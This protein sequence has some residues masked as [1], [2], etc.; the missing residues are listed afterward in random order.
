MCRPE[1]LLALLRCYTVFRTGEGGKTEKVV[2]RY[3]QFRAVEKALLRLRNGLNPRERSGIIWHTQGAG[4]SLTMLFLVRRMRFLDE[5]APWKIIF[6]TD[7]TDLENQLAGTASG[8]GQSVK[9]AEDIAKL[10]EYVQNPA[11][12]L[13]MGMIH[14]FQERD[15]STIFPVLNNSP[16]ILT[17]TDE[18]H[19]TQYGLLG[20]NFDRAV[21][22]AARIA[23]TGTPIAKTEE[24]FG[25]YIDKYTMRESI[26]DGTT[27]EIVYEGRTH[28]AEVPDK[29]GMDAAFED[30]F[31]EYNLAERLQILGYGSRDAYLEADPTIAA[32][33]KD[34]I[35]HYV[36]GIFTR[37]FKGQV[38]A[39]SQEA[40][41]RYKEHLEAALQD[42]IARLE[43]NNPNNVNL[44]QLKG[45]EVAVIISGIDRNDR[46]HL[47][48]FG[49]K[50]DHETA[51]KRFKLAFGEVSGDGAGQVNGQVGLLVVHNMLIT[52]F[53]APIEQVLYLDRV[54]R[55]HTL[56]QAIARVN[57]VYNEFKD[58]GFIVDYVGIGHHLK[59]ALDS[60]AEKEA[61]E[62]LDEL[63]DLGTLVAE[64]KQAHA[65]VWTVLHEGGITDFSDADAF[66]DLFYDEDIRFKYILAFRELSKAFDNLLPRKEA[67]E[68][69]PDYLNFVSVNEQASRHLNDSRL[70]M[71]GIPDKLRA[72]ADQHL[73][74]QG[75]EVKVKPISILDD[76]FQK[77]VGARTRAKTKAAQVEHAIRHFID[78]NLADDPELFASFAAQLEEILK[79]F[80]DNWDAIYRELEKLRERIR[81]K[82]R[83]QTYGLDRKKEMPVFRIL[84]SE[85]LGE[86][87]LESEDIS[88]L[89]SLTQD[90]FATIEREVRTSGF[91]NAPPM[92]NRLRGELQ[93]EVVLNHKEAFANLFRKRQEIISRLMEWAKE[94][95]RTIIG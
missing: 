26:A 67:L 95:H 19:R 1:H 85:L 14:K 23:Y 51:I 33:A 41:V 39:S 87:E 79:N 76:E 70:S 10:K 88:K 22:N 46:P 29:S 52:G 43:A 56:L 17:L 12:D 42:K 48:K 38:V 5:F 2:A 25:D 80:K 74:S 62:I 47:K 21:P 16:Y 40:A 20:A 93:N 45:L 6:I 81:T 68:F 75:I 61:Q 8:I 7:R 54:M 30:V 34:I 37:G 78:S 18:A 91:W 59:A 66:F 3:Q 83:E 36:E 65:K 9:V 73:Q 11:P 35:E 71:R 55:D 58:V 49:N 15:L 92:Q 31:S 32:K 50:S 4:K 27:L 57:R 82:E 72:I 89:V 94:N 24:T 64:L 77:E 63:K 53:D 60:Y 90:A 13:V 28:N 84:K 86:A 69:L 44:E